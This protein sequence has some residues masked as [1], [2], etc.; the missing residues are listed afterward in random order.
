LKADRINKWT[1]ILEEKYSQFKQFPNKSYRSE[2]KTLS[3][4]TAE[5]KFFKHAVSQTL[6]RFKKV[7]SFI[8]KRFSNSITDPFK[9]ELNSIEKQFE[10]ISANPFFKSIDE[11]QVIKQESLVLQKATGYSTIYNPNYSLEIRKSEVKLLYLN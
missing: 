1:P 5:N 4:N 2:Y 7:K 10:T 9:V 6:S 3:T 8:E 11:F